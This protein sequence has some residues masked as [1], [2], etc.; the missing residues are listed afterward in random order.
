LREQTLF[1]RIQT[2]RRAEAERCHHDRREEPSM[3]SQPRLSWFTAALLLAAACFPG[4][5]VEIF[6]ENEGGNHFMF[7]ENP[8]KFN[9]I[10]KEFMG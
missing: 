3:F 8:E 1:E 2:E 10:V 7:M 6:E 4:S 9:R 5:R